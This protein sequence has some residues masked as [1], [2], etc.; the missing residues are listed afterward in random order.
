MVLHL[1]LYSFH[2]LC[3]SPWALGRYRFAVSLGFG[4]INHHLA[5][6]LVQ[7]PT[8]ACSYTYLPGMDSNT[9]ALGFIVSRHRTC[10]A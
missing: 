5:D 6:T 2:Y 1:A 8:W 3:F 7:S 9:A 4:V 10:L